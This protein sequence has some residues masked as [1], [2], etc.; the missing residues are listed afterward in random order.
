MKCKKTNKS[1]CIVYSMFQNYLS[2]LISQK[3]QTNMIKCNTLHLKLQ[4][5]TLMY[6]SYINWKSKKKKNIYNNFESNK[7]I[8]DT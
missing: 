3:N 4:H 6:F 8:N 2:K 7:I 1:Y 5:F